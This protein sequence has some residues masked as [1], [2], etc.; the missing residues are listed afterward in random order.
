MG[1]WTLWSFKSSDKGQKVGNKSLKLVYKEKPVIRPRLARGPPCVPSVSQRDGFCCRL[2][3]R[4][5]TLVSDSDA[6]F[7]LK[8][9]IN[10]IIEA[11]YR[12][13]SKSE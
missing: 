7:V 1:T 6:A 4:A 8:D 13:L 11:I 12:P 3:K 2:C 9:K 10:H 5:S